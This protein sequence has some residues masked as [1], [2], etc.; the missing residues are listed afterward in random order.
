MT[1]SDSECVCTFLFPFLQKKLRK[2][3][4]SPAS[5]RATA[6]LELLLRNRPLLYHNSKSNSAL[7]RR[8]QARKPAKNESFCEGPQNGTFIVD[9]KEPTCQLFFAK[10]VHISSFFSLSVWKN[11]ESSND[12]KYKLL[13]L[14]GCLS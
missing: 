1:S 2:C 4:A 7:P 11:S 5:G 9:T 12:E 8:Q 13:L 6:F 14:L 10:M 3:R